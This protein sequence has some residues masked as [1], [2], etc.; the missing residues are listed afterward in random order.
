MALCASG[1][2]ISAIVVIILLHDMFTHNIRYLVQHSILGGILCMLFITMCNYGLES[3]NWVFIMFIP[4]YLLLNWFFTKN[5]KDDYAGTEEECDSCIE[6]INAC[7]C[8][9][10]TPSVPKEVKK[11]NCPAKPLKLPTTC[12]V[13]RYT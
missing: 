2:L 5:M 13:S 4:V 12:G 11:L 1:I 8:P 9:L 7:N 6:P 3:V 10:P